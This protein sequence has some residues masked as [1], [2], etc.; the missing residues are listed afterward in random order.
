M[1]RPTREALA[2]QLHAELVSHMGAVGRLMFLV[3]G[4]AVN[5][6]DLVSQMEAALKRQTD[7][8]GKDLSL[9]SVAELKVRK[10][11]AHRV[12]ASIRSDIEAGRDPGSR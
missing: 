2:A 6:L 9:Y 5:P 10:E 7:R 12:V 1:D 4:R 8:I 3:S 11:I